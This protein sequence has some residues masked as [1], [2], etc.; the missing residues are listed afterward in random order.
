MRS[1]TITVVV[2]SYNR[3]QSLRTAVA[4]ALEQPLV[5]EV[6]VVDDASQRAPALNGLDSSRLRVVCHDTNRG[7]CAVRNT[8]LALAATGFVT[9]LDDDDQ[10]LPGAYPPLVQALEEL[11]AQGKAGVAVGAVQV[12]RGGRVVELRRPPCSEPGQ[13]WGLDRSLLSGRGCSFACKQAAL[14][15][16]DLLREIGGWNDELRSRSQTEL[17]F[18]L[19]ARYPVLGIDHP[20]YL[21]SRD[22]QN[23]LTADR[24]VREQ[25]YAYL[26]AHYGHLLQDRQRRDYFEKN[27]RLNMQPASRARSLLRRLRNLVTGEKPVTS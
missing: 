22:S 20:M 9:F 17:F 12:V 27:H 5:D 4:S 25:S 3:P 2:S 6:I 16:T 15:P 8:G 10:L 7:I 24:S 11:A 19:C 26:Q 13:I 18:R 1:A 23:H 21:L 14:Y